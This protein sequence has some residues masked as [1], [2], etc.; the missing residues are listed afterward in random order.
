MGPSRP[1]D[2]QKACG[3]ASNGRD[4]HSPQDGQ[5]VKRGE[6]IPLV[7]GKQQRLPQRR[8]EADCEA[9]TEHSDAE[10]G[11]EI[12]RQLPSPCF[13]RG[14]HDRKGDARMGHPHR[15][16]GCSSVCVAAGRIAGLGAGGRGE[17]M[18]DGAGAAS[19]R[20]P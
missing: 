9:A 10:D 2:A 18:K 1:I 19:T 17:T 6:D 13:S 3:Q 20:F 8:P 14:P 15:G 11:D 12:A 7:E 4:Q 16:G 5:G